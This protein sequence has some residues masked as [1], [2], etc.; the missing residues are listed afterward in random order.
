MATMLTY[1]DLEMS[2]VDAQLKRDGE[3]F[4][5]LSPARAGLLIALVE[6]SRG[7]TQRPK[8]PVPAR[9]RL[10]FGGLWATLRAGLFHGRLMDLSRILVYFSASATWRA[11]E[12]GQVEFKFSR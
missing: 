5:V 12:D 1:P 8:P 11:R 10:M 4:V 7:L 3:L 9:L 2:K 6:A